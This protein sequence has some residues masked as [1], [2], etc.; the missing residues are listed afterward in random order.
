M[1]LVC[2]LVSLAQNFSDIYFETQEVN[3][4]LKILK[5]PLENERLNDMQL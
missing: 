4:T 5:L 3:E 2:D 1:H